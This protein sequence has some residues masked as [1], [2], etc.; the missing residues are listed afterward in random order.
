GDG[1]P[2]TQD[3]VTLSGLAITGGVAD[4]GGGISSS[5][6]DLTLVDS[7]V[8]GNLAT[9]AIP[10]VL[11][12]SGGGIA[13]G[14]GSLNLIDS[15]V[16]DNAADIFAGGVFGLAE[17]PLNISNSII[18]GNSA[19]DGG[20]IAG[21]DPLTL[22]GS[23][24]SDNTAASTGGG[25]LVP[26]VPG[27]ASGP[28]TISNSTI[29]NNSATT[30]GGIYN[31]GGQVDITN[32]T[33][34][35]NIANTGSGISSFGDTI[36]QT[37]LTSSIVSGNSGTDV[38]LS[39]PPTVDVADAPNSFTSNGNNLIGD[40]NATDSFNGSGDITGN[41]DP[42]LAPLAD[43]G[44]PTPTIAL[45]PGSPAIDA[46]SNPSNLT[47]DQRGTGFSRVIGAAADI[48]AFEV[49]GD[50]PDDPTDA[51]DTPAP[52]GPVDLN[53]DG[54]DAVEP[55]TDV[56]NIFRVLAGAPQAVVVPDGVGQQDIVNA[57]EAFPDLALDV[58]D[59]GTVEPATDVLNIFRVLAGAPQ[60]VVVPDGVSQ[61]TVVDA[62][63]ALVT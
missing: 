47:T 9:T 18:S 21:V 15:I 3:L 26:A 63:E 39:T 29:A 42:G 37:T 10:G 19:T 48:G 30:G 23:T 20:A 31:A 52:G 53:V 13:V 34:T 7:V 25:I 17:S 54:N 50:A 51:P 35:A 40:G 61:Q 16:S 28:I 49:E 41:T 38:D 12:G 1:N 56:L 32:S 59:S 14:F 2:D 46:G 24:I 36:A 22:T 5:D 33:I 11:S 44:G 57:V 60:A 4:I 45:L 27:S 58:D 43:N 8:S 62:V 6:S 55:A